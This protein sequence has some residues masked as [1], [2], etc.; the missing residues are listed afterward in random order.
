[1]NTPTKQI[2]SSIRAFS[3]LNRAAKSGRKAAQKIILGIRFEGGPLSSGFFLSEHGQRTL[4]AAIEVLKDLE[5]KTTNKQAD[6]W[7][8]DIYDNFRDN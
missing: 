4:S 2:I 6:S 1:M 3:E 5:A 7:S 8:C